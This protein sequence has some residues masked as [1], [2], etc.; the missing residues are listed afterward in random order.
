MSRRDSLVVALTG[1][2]VLLL[3]NSAY[4]FGSSAPT[5]A[6]FTNVALHPALGTAL[7]IVAVIAIR[8]RGFPSGPFLRLLAVFSLFA[9]VLGIVLIVT[10]ATRRYQPIVTA[11]VIAGGLAGLALLAAAFT[12]RQ[13]AGDIVGSTPLRMSMAVVA[14]A[15]ATAGLIAWRAPAARAREYAIRN[16][17]SVPIAMD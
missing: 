3:L 7:A 17:Q 5:L 9:A 15:A 4:L 14:L 16:P 10:G 2:F 8:R 6:H 13:P 1:A 12:R 11:H